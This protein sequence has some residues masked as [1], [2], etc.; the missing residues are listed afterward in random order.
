MTLR[1]ASN[2]LTETARAM[3]DDNRVK[4]LEYNH[5]LIGMTYGYD[6]AE[7]MTKGVSVTD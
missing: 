6:Y 7:A 1:E 4:G 2:F 3:G 5:S